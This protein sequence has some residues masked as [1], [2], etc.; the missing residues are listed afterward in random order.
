MGSEIERVNLRLRQVVPS[1]NVALPFGLRKPRQRVDEFL[2]PR[3]RDNRSQV[4]ACLVRRSSGICAVFCHGT[5]V[6]P[7]QELSNL[8]PPQLL[9][10]HS[11]TPLLPF[12]DRGQVF[13]ARPRRWVPGTKVVGHGSSESRRHRRAP[14][15]PVLASMPDPLTRRRMTRLAG[16]R[17]T[18]IRATVTAIRDTRCV[19]VAVEDNWPVSP[20][21]HQATSNPS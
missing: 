17:L 13:G 19:A 1:C 20:P 16:F 5:L 18:S 11:A 7:V 4:F 21:L 3:P 12:S 10:G 15:P 14:A 9:D 2:I 6:N 8:R